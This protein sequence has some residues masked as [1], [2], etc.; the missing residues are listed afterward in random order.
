[1]PARIEGQPHRIPADR[2]QT[3][4]NNVAVGH[5]GA[6]SAAA[7]R[8]GLGTRMTH[9]SSDLCSARHPPRQDWRP[10]PA[11]PP[12][13]RR[14]VARLLRRRGPANGSAPVGTT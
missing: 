5:A 1:L 9:T 3:G 10:L 7:W 12:P 14:L 13:A 11:M 8:F 4:E 6:H 2:W